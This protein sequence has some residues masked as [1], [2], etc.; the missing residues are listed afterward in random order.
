[1]DPQG[2]AQKKFLEQMT[3]QFL[4]VPS[5]NA[6]TPHGRMTFSSLAE[7]STAPARR[8]MNLTESYSFTPYQR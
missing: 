4:S 1:M 2:K 5:R 6:Q 3:G 7:I 8:F